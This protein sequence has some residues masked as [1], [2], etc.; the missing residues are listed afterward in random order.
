MDNKTV[1][2]NCYILTTRKIGWNGKQYRQVKCY[3]GQVVA[4]NGFGSHLRY[5]HN[6]SR[7]E[8]TLI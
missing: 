7:D 5:K 6:K 8:V 2:N 1:N 4:L 3:C